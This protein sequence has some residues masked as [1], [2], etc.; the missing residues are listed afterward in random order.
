MSIKEKTE[1]NEREIFYGEK[2]GKMI[3]CETISSSFDQDLSKFY[4]FHE[5][6]EQL[7]P[8]IHKTCEKYEFNGSL[9]FKWNGKG[10]GKPILFMSHQDVVEA[11]G[12]W[13]HD[14]FG[15]EI[16]DG[17]VWGRG[18]VDTKGSLFCFLQAAEELIG[19]GYVPECDVY[20]ASSC[21]EEIGGEGAPLTV[22]WLQDHEVQLRFLMDEGGMIK[23]EPMKG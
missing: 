15:G 6:L 19:K 9:L 21:T 11:N 16:I 22:K 1:S 7:F 13:E 4:R 3:R 18:T 20:L 8:N 14:P 12:Q 23:E 2:L 5:V 10:N 17:A